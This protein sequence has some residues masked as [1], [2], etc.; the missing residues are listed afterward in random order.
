MNNQYNAFFAHIVS[1][2]RSLINRPRYVRFKVIHDDEAGVYVA[3]S[4]DVRGMVIEAASIDE[5]LEEVRLMLPEFLDEP[6]THECDDAHEIKFD[7]RV[8]A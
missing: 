1:A 6:R 5:V 8:H 2:Y 4:P 7:I 3:T